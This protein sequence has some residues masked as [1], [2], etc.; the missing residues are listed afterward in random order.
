MYDEDED[1]I[2]M[3]SSDI[4]CGG[5]ESRKDGWW[6]CG[7]L[8]RPGQEGMLL[9]RCRMAQADSALMLLAAIA[10]CVAAVLGYLRVRRGY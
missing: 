9:S 8:T 10:V 3:V 7:C 1:V 6:T 2:K 4:I 5:V